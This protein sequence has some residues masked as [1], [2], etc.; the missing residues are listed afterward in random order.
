M[1]KKEREPIYKTRERDNAHKIE[2]D[3]GNMIRV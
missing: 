3:D 1:I 2:K